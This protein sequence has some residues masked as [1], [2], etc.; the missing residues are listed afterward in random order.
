MMIMT[1]AQK[2]LKRRRV[3]AAVRVVKALGGPTMGAEIIRKVL[4]A[5]IDKVSLFNWTKNGVPPRWS[6]DIYDLT[7]ISPWI[8][9]PDI[10]KRKEVRVHYRLGRKRQMVMRLLAKAA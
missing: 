7:G 4:R 9:N 2:S 6:E 8:T 10:F 1:E 5:K 3:K